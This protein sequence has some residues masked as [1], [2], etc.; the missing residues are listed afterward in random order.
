MD[1]AFSDCHDLIDMKAILSQWLPN[2]SEIVAIS[3]FNDVDFLRDITLVP[4]HD[5]KCF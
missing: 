1:F 3:H 2:K 4:F 5:I